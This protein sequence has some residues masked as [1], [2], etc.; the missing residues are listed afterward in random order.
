MQRPLAFLIHD[1]E[2]KHVQ[3][4][5]DT[6]STCTH[7]KLQGISQSAFEKNGL[8]GLL[9]EKPSCEGG[10]SFPNECC[11]T[12]ELENSTRTNSSLFIDHQIPRKDQKSKHKSANCIRSLFDS[13]A[14]IQ[15]AGVPAPNLGEADTIVLTPG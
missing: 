4:C 15:Q 6:W 9:S 3:A 13:C 5:V 11:V 2:K 14:P 8:G 10:G 1:I 12:L 7:V